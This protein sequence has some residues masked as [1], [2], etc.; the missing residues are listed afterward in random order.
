MQREQE[1]IMG[2]RQPIG[3][4]SIG[5][6][7]IHLLVAASDGNTT[8]EKKLNQSMLAE[9]IGDVKGGVV[10]IK[11]LYRALKDLATL[12]PA[13]RKAESATIIAIATQEMREVT[14]GPDIIDL[15]GS[16][17]H[18]QAMLITSQE[19]AALDYCWATFPPVLQNPLLVVDSGGGSTQVIQGEGPTPAFAQSLPIGAGNLTQQFL[20]HDPPTKK[21]IQSFQAHIAAQVDSLPIV[22][23]LRSAILMGGSADTLL[24]FVADPTKQIVTHADLQRALH[25][26]CKKSAK[27]IAHTHHLLVERARLLPAGVMIL[28]HMLSRYGLDEAYIKADGI[29]GGLVV[30]Y[31]R[32]GDNWRQELP[33]PPASE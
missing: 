31:A 21:E 1:R 14:N 29:R 25:T 11:A 10:P 4:I 12:V 6:N 19:E 2:A 3:V 16:T 27:E 20:K 8:F 22:L 33:L 30:S 13:A 9:L 26:L 24:Q 7:D 15:V 23:P 18:I 5:S 32:H 28:T 17:L